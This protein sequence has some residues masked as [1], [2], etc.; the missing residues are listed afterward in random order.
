MDLDTLKQITQD[1]LHLAKQFGASSAD[2]EVSYGTGQNVS[3]RLGEAENIEYNKDKGVSTTVYFGHQKGH[4]SSSDLSAQALKDTV[5]AACNI[6]KYTA[7]DEFCGLADAA[8]MATEFPDL[9]LYHP[10]QINIDQAIELAKRCEAAALAVDSTRITNSE[11]ASVYTN[12]GV[13]AYANSHGFIGGYPSTRH[14]ISC[15]VIAE[16]D[17]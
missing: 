15:S 10:W 16:Q 1:V 2:V 17:N 12:E 6:A 11:G 9:D 4:A 5:E 13:F 3:V 7:K 14:S 8:L